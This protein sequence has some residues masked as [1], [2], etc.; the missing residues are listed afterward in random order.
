MW[1][2]FQKGCY[3]MSGLMLSIAQKIGENKVKKNSQAQED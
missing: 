2:R 1:I 3:K